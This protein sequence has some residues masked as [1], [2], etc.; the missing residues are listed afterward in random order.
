MGKYDYLN[1]VKSIALIFQ[2][3]S[4]MIHAIPTICNSEI[5]VQPSTVQTSVPADTLQHITLPCSHCVCVCV[6]VCLCI[7]VWFL[8]EV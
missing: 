2:W 1:H 5:I 8:L 6:C 4:H 3:K 7:H